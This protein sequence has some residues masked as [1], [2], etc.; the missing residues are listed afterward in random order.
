MEP[1]IVDNTGSLIRQVERWIIPDTDHEL[2]VDKMIN[3][4]SSRGLRR[5]FVEGGGITVSRFFEAQALDR[6]HV[7]IAPLLVGQGRSALQLNGVATM[8]Q[9]HRPPHSIYRMGEDILWDFDVSGM[10]MA[11]CGEDAGEE[12]GEE[13]VCNR[14]ADAS[15]ASVVRIV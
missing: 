4:L 11:G 13:T 6:L 9:A 12:V 5:L 14:L 2:S 15:T 7:A 1:E 3:Q 10:K 8:M